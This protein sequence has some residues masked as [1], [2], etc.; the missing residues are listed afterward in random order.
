MGGLRILGC[1][2]KPG[3][4]AP[5]E[6]APSLRFQVG[7]GIVGDA[8]GGP[9]SPRHVL[10]V[11]RTTYRELRLPDAV[12]RENLLVAGMPV[13]DLQSGDLLVS[14]DGVAIRI[15]F[16]CDPCAKLNEVRPTL[17]KEV[18][19]RRGM[20]GRVVHGGEMRAGETLF[21][22]RGIFPAIP[23]RVPDR[24]FG[25]V[26]AIPR[27][28]V[29][30]LTHV[31]RMIG[32]TKSYVRVLPRILNAAPDNV[33]VHRVV[34]TDG[35]LPEGDVPGR[36]ERLAEEGLINRDGEIG[37]ERLWNGDPF[38]DTIDTLNGDLGAVVGRCAAFGA[39]S[40][41]ATLAVQ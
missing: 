21:L 29:T 8:N 15:T 1:L 3:S 31:T 37:S 41:S 22:R 20:L 16:P 19:G 36:R 13:S 5:M 11:D 6:E 30:T 38:R 23:S 35:T 24:V 27:S 32:V 4:G 18:T 14:M 25:V 40:E 9:G 33:P 28:R 2:R 26:R 7:T 17:A 34:R 12:L 10:L 39:P